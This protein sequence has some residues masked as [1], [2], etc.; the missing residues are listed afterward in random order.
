M[1]DPGA[2]SQQIETYRPRYVAFPRPC[3]LITSFCD[4]V[5]KNLR[6]KLEPQIIEVQERRLYG[7]ELSKNLTRLDILAELY[8][9]WKRSLKKPTK[10]LLK[11]PKIYDLRCLPAVFAITNLDSRIN[12]TEHR[13]LDIV[14]DLPNIVK[15]FIFGRREELRRLVPI[16]NLSEDTGD[17]LE[18]ATSVFVAPYSASF[19]A[20]SELR[21]CEIAI[22][23]PMLSVAHTY[24]ADPDAEEMGYD[25]PQPI[26]CEFS[27]NLSETAASLVKLLGKDPFKTTAEEMDAADAKFVCETCITRTLGHYRNRC[28]VEHLQ[29]RVD[30]FGWKEAVRPSRLIRT[31]TE[32]SRADYHRS[33]GLTGQASAD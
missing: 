14:T 28:D 6:T 4:T 26:L 13:F 24:R 7:N 11:Y 3:N 30:V 15:R 17:A 9:L 5:W 32:R 21:S 29:I 10:E 31:Q 19:N 25:I 1:G 18:L 27:P 20:A 33:F 12:V 16:E 8:E 23:W 2:Q 22:G